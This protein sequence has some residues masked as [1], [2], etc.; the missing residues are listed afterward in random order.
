MAR[1]TFKG[2]EEY[3]LL[4]SRLKKGTEE[5]A[6][7]AIYAGAAVVADEMRANIQSLPVIRGYGT[8][9]DPLPGG[10]TD[11][12]KRGLLA[13]FGISSLKNN[14]G[15]LNVK[16]GFDGYNSTKTK[17]YPKGQPN[18]M[19]ARAIESGSSIRKKRPFIRPA[20]D[21]A[22]KKA[23]EKGQ[24]VIDERIEAITK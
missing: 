16:L 5:I 2:L 21:K 1:L 10:V 13:G 23:I 8:P 19:I 11:R 3:E 24:A 15:Y 9:E 18:A 12:Q 14:N 6:G 22:K 17:K 7:R 4:I 20:V